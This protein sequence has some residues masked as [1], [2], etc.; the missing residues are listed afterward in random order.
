MP[1]PILVDPRGYTLEFVDLANYWHVRISDNGVQFSWDANYPNSRAASL[2][3]WIDAGD[4][5]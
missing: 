1:Y 4:L 5:Q 2:S 3:R